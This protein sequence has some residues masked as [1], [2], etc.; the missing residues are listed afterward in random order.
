MESR[1]KLRRK[2]IYMVSALGQRKCSL[3]HTVRKRWV[4][5]QPADRLAPSFLIAYI[6]PDAYAFLFNVN[7]DAL[8]PGHDH[9]FAQSHCIQQ[10]GQSNEFLWQADHGYGHNTRFTVSS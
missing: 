5:Q 10:T 2:T 7:T 8:I 6:Y 1:F 4:R 3:S 9:R